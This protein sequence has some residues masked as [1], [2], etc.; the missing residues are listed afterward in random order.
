ML[1]I[2]IDDNAPLYTVKDIELPVDWRL[3]D[4]IKLKDMGDKILS[5]KRYLAIKVK[6]EVMP[7]EYNIIINPQHPGFTNHVKALKMNSPDV[8]KR[9]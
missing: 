8:D 1:T 3:P 7:D 2:E 5:E 4:N 9:L 6:S